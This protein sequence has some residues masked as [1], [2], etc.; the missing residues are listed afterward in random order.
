MRIGLYGGCFNPVHQGHLAAARG[1]MGALGLDRVVF[2]PSGMPPLKGVGGLAAGTHRLAMLTAALANEPGMES[3][4][5]EIEREG[6]SYTIDTVS[7][8]RCAFPDQ[9]ELFFLLGDDCV[10]RLA[11]WKGIARL[12][13][14][15]RFAILPRDK[16]QPC[17]RDD[18]L[19]WLDIPRI[20]ASSTRIRAMLVAGEHPP[21]TLIAPAVLEYALEHDLY[22]VGAERSYA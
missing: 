7:Q 16:R 5:I 3:S 22:A 1:A 2:I 12:H 13:E 18:R 6:P 10:E 15:V 14:M 11:R 17:V 4:A 9:A 21:A 20:E 19:I 8:L